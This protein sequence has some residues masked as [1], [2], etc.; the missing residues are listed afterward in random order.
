MWKL[1]RRQLILRCSFLFVELKGAR[2]LSH[3]VVPRAETQQAAS[4]LETRGGS[5]QLISNVRLEQHA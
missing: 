5:T 3:R 4:L 2:L 1:R